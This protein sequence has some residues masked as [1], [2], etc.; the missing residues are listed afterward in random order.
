MKTYQELPLMRNFIAGSLGLCC[1]IHSFQYVRRSSLPLCLSV[2]LSLSLFRSLLRQIMRR[3]AALPRGIIIV[4]LMAF[5]SHTTTREWTFRIRYLS[6]DARSNMPWI[7]REELNETSEKLF[8]S[9]QPIKCVQK[10]CPFTENRLKFEPC[11]GQKRD[12][13]VIN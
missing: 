8:H 3:Y 9:A 4:F 11:I 6:L 12:N 1:S 5:Y 10:I 7:I 13:T 2:S